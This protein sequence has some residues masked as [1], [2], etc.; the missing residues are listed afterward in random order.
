MGSSCNIF[1][2]DDN[3][4]LL[5]SWL[6]SDL[7]EQSSLVRLGRFICA[8]SDRM[9]LSH[10]R[11]QSKA[12][13]VVF[14]LGSVYLC[15]ID[16]QHCYRIC[17][18]WRQPRQKQAPWSKCFEDGS[19]HHSTSFAVD[20]AHSWRFGSNWRTQR[21]CVQVVLSDGHWSLRC[22]WNDRHCLRRKRA[23]PRNTKRSRSIY[24]RVSMLHSRVVN[25]A[26]GGKQTDPRRNEDSLPNG[27]WAQ[28]CGNVFVNFLF[29]IVRSVVFLEYGKNESIFIAKNGIGIILS[30][31]EIRHLCAS[32]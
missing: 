18:C 24:D 31:L 27:G 26:I 32:R 12:S 22:C 21:T 15:L 23:R 19:L 11:F 30:V 3:S 20:V 16:T 2:S 17:S 8:S 28:H 7:Q 9:D 14:C 29:L 10:N 4:V 6:S 1:R 25:L 13:P 5:S